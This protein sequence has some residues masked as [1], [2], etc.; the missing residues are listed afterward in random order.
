MKTTNTAEGNG[1]KLSTN[2]ESSSTAI[3]R[4]PNTEHQFR[5]DNSSAISKAIKQSSILPV[6]TESDALE[7]EIKQEN[8]CPLSTPLPPHAISKIQVCN[9][10]HFKF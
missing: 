5:N 1:Q 9:F 10:Y 6:A 7:A 2:D 8:P 3:D 4:P